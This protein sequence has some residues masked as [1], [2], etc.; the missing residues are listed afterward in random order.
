MRRTPARVSPIAPRAPTPQAGK[1]RFDSLPCRNA[2]V[3]VRWRP[4]ASEERRL[5][6]PTIQV[7][8]ADRRGT[9]ASRIFRGRVSACSDG[10][11][12]ATGDTQALVLAQSESRVEHA[13]QRRHENASERIIRGGLRATARRS[14]SPCCRSSLDVLRR[15]RTAAGAKGTESETH[16]PACGTRRSN[17]VNTSASGHPVDLSG[18]R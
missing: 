2:A 4:Q 11:R 9:L 3:R 8:G 7:P 13:A 10:S 16:F 1:M 6:H 15:T 17:C 12:R 14:A 18:P 5:G